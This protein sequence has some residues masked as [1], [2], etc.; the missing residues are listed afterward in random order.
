MSRKKLVRAK[1]SPFKQG[2]LVTVD[3]EA[4]E[5]LSHQLLN[6]IND[7]PAWNAKL[8]TVYQVYDGEQI[9]LHTK[10]V[11]KKASFSIIVPMQ[12]VKKLSPEEA[13]REEIR[14]SWFSTARERKPADVQH[15]YTK[16][17]Q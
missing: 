1:A 16:I 3:W 10:T 17:F 5:I 11:G 8:L 4:F 9:E 13:T 15:P 2:D 14:M 7:H 6:S 12:F